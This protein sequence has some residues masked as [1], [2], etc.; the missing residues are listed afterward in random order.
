MKTFLLST[1]VILGFLA[2]SCSCKAKV[3]YDLD[4]L[5]D[6]SDSIEMMAE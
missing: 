2:T 6:P 1:A 4:V 3:F 5:F